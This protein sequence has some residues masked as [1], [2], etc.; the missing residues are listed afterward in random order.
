M[1]I[2]LDEKDRAIIRLLQDSLPVTSCPYQ[3]LAE[4]LGITQEEILDRILRMKKEGL[5]RR[6]G[7]IL[8]HAKAGYSFNALTAWTITPSEG[9]TT[10][11][12]QDRVGEILANDS[13]I[14]HCYARV[15]NETFP[16]PMFAMIHAASQE[17]LDDTLSLLKN[18]LPEEQVR[19]LRTRHEWKKTSMQYV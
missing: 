7:A 19:V 14:S 6:M 16:Y 8:R 11:Q 15:V 12:A 17:E 1:S 18:R 13:H 5:I 10:E 2:R 9:E 4:Q 3:E